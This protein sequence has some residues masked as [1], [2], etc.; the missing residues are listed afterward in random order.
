MLTSY[1]VNQMVS[2]IAGERRDTGLR[3]EDLAHYLRNIPVRARDP[4]RWLPLPTSL[5]EP[6]KARI[7]ARRQEREFIALWELSPH[8]LQDIGVILSRGADLPDHLVAAPEGVID[9]VNAADPAQVKRAESEYPPK[10][11]APTR[12]KR[13]SRASPALSPAHAFS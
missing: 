9:H 6:L 13:T 3:N 5:R 10:A 2:A 12:E 7:E 8:L 11:P 1:F 4:L